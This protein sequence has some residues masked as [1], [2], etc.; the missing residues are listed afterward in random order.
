MKPANN[1]PEDSARNSQW[2]E[3]VD[4][5]RDDGSGSLAR[6]R[7]D[8]WLFAAPDPITPIDADLAYWRRLCE[9]AED[10]PRSGGEWCALR[11]LGRD[12]RALRECYAAA[13]HPRV[14]AEL[15]REA[16]SVSRHMRRCLRRLQV[17][18][19]PPANADHEA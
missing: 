13:H 14:R 15:L 5:H 9:A 19:P 7:G 6:A 1:E 17:A 8:S 12:L 16:R 3:G 10:G 11:S 18:A 2:I 4:V